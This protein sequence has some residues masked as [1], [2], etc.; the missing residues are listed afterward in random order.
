[1]VKL[2]LGVMVLTEPLIRAENI[3]YSYD[4]KNEALK[5]IS[6]GISEGR[7]IAILGHNG[8]GKST[9]FMHFNGLLKPDSGRFYFAGKPFS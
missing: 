8:A 9:L 4:M 1:M 5:G 3:H 2:I 7:K 6:I